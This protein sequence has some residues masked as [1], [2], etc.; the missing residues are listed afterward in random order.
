[1]KKKYHDLDVEARIV[2]SSLK[3]YDMGFAG[4]GL[5]YVCTTNTLL[6]CKEPKIQGTIG[7]FF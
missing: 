5:E 6:S 3:A 1:M 7:P 4:A 2:F